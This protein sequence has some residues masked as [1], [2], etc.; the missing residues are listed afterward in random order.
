MFYKTGITAGLIATV[1]AA[2]AAVTKIIER[3]V[4]SSASV[5]SSTTASAAS[6]SSSS[7]F[8]PYSYNQQ[9][10][11]NSAAVS[12]VA[13]VAGIPASEIPG[14]TDPVPPVISSQV[15][16]VTS[17][18]PYSGT[19]TT[20]GALSTIALASEVPI[21]PP[22][23]AEQ[24]YVP[25]GTLHDPQPIPYQPAGGLGTNGTEPVYRVQ[26][27]FDY[28]S[29]LL[30][31]Y[32]EWIELD[33]F[34]HILARFPEEEFTAAG[35]TP[36]DR[37]LI[38][39]M[40]NQES[41]HATMLSN[42]LGGPGGATPQCTY[43]YPFT[44][45]TEA[46]D[47]CQKLTRYGESGVWG[48]QA[49]LDSREVAQLLDQSIATEARQQIIFRQFSGLFPMP[50]WFETGI[51][52]SWA[53]TLLAPYISSCPANSKRL[54][55]Q[56]FPEL[57]ILNQPNIARRNATQTGFNETAGFG[58][59]APSNSSLAPIDSCVGNN[60]T[61]FD[62][63]ASISQNRSIPLS[64]PGREV[65]LQWENPGKPVGP[66]NSYITASSAGTAEWAMWVSQLNITYSPLLNV[67]TNNGANSAMTIQPDVST[68]EG[69]PA[70]NGT[71][72]LALTDTNQTYSAFNLSN[73]NPHVVA[74][75]MYQ[76][77]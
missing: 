58:P 57:K 53:W 17:H 63:S 22:R 36:S 77:G 20:T 29:I 64:Y 38:E 50:V 24:T 3:Q 43:N 11:V 26:S 73:V 60:V 23:P 33:L 35:L 52:Q 75:A 65:F 67:T 25:D 47:F 19:P 39:F 71:M 8:L 54:V 45:V 56:N 51:P 44:T 9:P 55:W 41:G 7:P 48:F 46:F 2:P 4:E 14:A 15:T 12:S 18:G 16:G 32:Q 1:A 27:D 28:Q 49:H 30:G 69:D 70:I 21:L 62:C 66:N 72:F 61:G 74:L 40:A 59:A 13:S 10:S 37:H 31:L 68:F 5:T 42:L 76:A 6:A 34:H